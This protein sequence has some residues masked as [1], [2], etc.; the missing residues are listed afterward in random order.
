MQLLELA[1][2]AARDLSSSTIIPRF[3]ILGITTDEEL[4]GMFSDKMGSALKGCT[5]PWLEPAQL[6]RADPLQ[7][8]L[9]QDEVARVVMGEP[10]QLRSE[11]A[12]V[13]GRITPRACGRFTW[14]DCPQPDIGLVGTGGSRLGLNW[15]N[16]GITTAKILLCES[17]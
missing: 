9:F 1:G 11:F 2:N 4:M 15:L 3:V 16:S 13:G 17:V 10:I 8:I 6:L 5:L 12:G 14:H 7:S